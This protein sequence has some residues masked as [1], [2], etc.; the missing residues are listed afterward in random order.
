MEYVPE[1]GDMVW[2]AP[3]FKPG[4]E[5]HGRWPVLVLSP[6]AY[7]AK[8]GRAILC[9]LITQ[10]KRQPFEVRIP[11]GMGF[12]GAILADQVMS[13]EWRERAPELIGRLP[14]LTMDEVL[15]KLGALL[16]R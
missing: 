13:L 1:R 6:A 3:D 15:A 2:I 9:P 4:G 12:Q 10:T 7:N 16:G 11:A 5:R 14:G 8:V